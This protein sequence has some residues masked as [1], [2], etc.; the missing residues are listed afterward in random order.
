M[1]STNVM[2]PTFN[3]DQLDI[4]AE[5]SD[6]QQVLGLSFDDIVPM[7]LDQIINTKPGFENDQVSVSLATS[8]TTSG[9]IPTC[10]EEHNQLPILDEKWT[11]DFFSAAA[12]IS[13]NT[14]TSVPGLGQVPVTAYLDNGSLILS[15]RHQSASVKILSASGSPPSLVTSVFDGSQSGHDQI[16]PRRPSNTSIQQLSTAATPATSM[17]TFVGN[18]TVLKRHQVFGTLDPESLVLVS[19]PEE[20]NGV[21]RGPA[22]REGVD[23]QINR[24]IAITAGVKRGRPQASSYEVQRSPVYL[25]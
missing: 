19:Q 6:L 1:H 9:P 2:Y 21:C 8:P 24:E 4:F 11:Q 10:V 18:E 25:E 22:S 3:D 16:V 23:G 15:G 17:A 7:D 12:P 5:D 13:T 14:T 20:E